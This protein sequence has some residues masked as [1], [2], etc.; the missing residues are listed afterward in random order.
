MPYPN[1]SSGLSDTGT[2]WAQYLDTQYT[3]ASPFVIAQ[4]VSS[5][6][7]NNS[8]EVINSQ[9]PVG[10]TSMYGGGK[11]LPDLFGDYYTMTLRFSAKNSNVNGSFDFAI[12]LGGAIGQQFQQTLVFS[13]GANAEQ[14]FSIV[15]PGYAGQVFKDNGGTIKINSLVGDTS[16][17]GISLQ[18]ERTHKAR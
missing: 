16:I 2:G 11:I 1:G 7:P 14:F 4:G 13:K 10:V 6:L 12:D 18:I 3:L 9:I 5:T 17:Y 8:A 15:S